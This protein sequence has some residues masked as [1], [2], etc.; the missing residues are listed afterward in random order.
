MVS[1]FGLGTLTWGRDTDVDTARE[2]LELFVEA[3]GT[4]VETSHDHGG[5]AAPTVLGEL[6]A[7]SALRASLVLVASA[8]VGRRAGEPVLEASR[9]GLLA[10]LDAT[11]TAL[12]T[13]HLDV[14]HVR[15][16]GERTTLDETLSAAEAALHSG[17]VRYVGLADP[18]GWQLG[19]A[20]GS[21]RGQAAA[22]VSVA[23][24]YSLLERGLEAEV[25]PGAAHLGAGII[26]GAP[27]AR[28]VLTG[29]YRGGVP[30]DARAA[31][32]HLTGLVTPLLE[33]GSRAVV[34]AVGTAAAGL[35]LS[36]LEVALAWVRDRPGVDA[37]LL[38]ARTT[39]QLRSA[40]AAATLTLPD[41]IAIAL[42]EVS[43]PPTP[44]PATGP[45][46]Q[47]AW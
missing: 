42:D 21:L 44:Y 2:H 47:P 37:V 34:E 41:E 33:P 18:A 11:L 19:Y 39:P 14:W 3:G 46:P 36:M 10:E 35:G 12:R 1:A 43:A 6:M 25:V 45:G 7:G 30:A 5:G 22:P 4:L 28:G 31:S 27:L 24:A 15:L 9:R 8:G 20:A 32:P 26:A 16:D 40:L 23:A 38:G 13:D 29:K 17:R